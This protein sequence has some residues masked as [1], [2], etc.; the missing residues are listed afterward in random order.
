MQPSPDTILRLP[1]YD[2]LTKSLSGSH[3]PV[4]DGLRAVAVSLVILY[5]SGWVIPG[6]L[7]VLIFFVLSGFLITWLML[8]E[9]DRFG[10][11]SLEQFYI[12]RSLRIFPAFYIFATLGLGALLLFHKHIVW[13]QA[14]AALTYWSNYYQAIHGDPNTLFSHTWSLAIEEQFYLLWPS[15]FLLFL[16]KRGALVKFLVATIALVW[17]HRLFL[18]VVVHLNRGYIYEAFD[19]RAD[20]LAAGCL[21]A[22]LLWD[23]KLKRLFNL[24]CSSQWLTVSVITLLAVSSALEIHYG[25]YYRDAVGL[26]TDSLLVAVLI[27]QLISFFRTAAFGWLNWAWMRHLGALSYSMYLYQ[28]AVIS[29]ARKLAAGRPLI[30]EV[31][32]V[33]VL[34]ILCAEAS[35]RLVE[36]PALRL[37]EK[38]GSARAG[39][40][41]RRVFSET[42]DPLAGFVQ[43]EEV[44]APAP[45]P[46]ATEPKRLRT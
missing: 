42:P 18:L 15:I 44:P 10:A 37:K 1:H 28:Q 31:I 17:I 33:F 12:R 3:L 26:G 6:G 22:V 8:K 21:L 36:R 46:P 9:A 7:G 20:S 32:V 24:V 5:H 19:T 2:R 13:P 43:R 34:T 14:F 38:F 40:V 39:T 29:P 16:R 25:R 27:P 4:L 41:R 11:V 23:G 45:M 30:V 35:Y